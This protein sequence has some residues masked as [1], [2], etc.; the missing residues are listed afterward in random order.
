MKTKLLIV[1]FSICVVILSLQIK[2]QAFSF[3][4][5]N[6][7]SDEICAWIQ[8]DGYYYLPDLNGEDIEGVKIEE[9]NIASS[10]QYIDSEGTTN[11]ELRNFDASG[12]GDNYLGFSED[13][14]YVY[15]FTD[16]SEKIDTGT[17]CYMKT[18]Y[19]GTTSAERSRYI[20]KVDSNVFT[21]VRPVIQKDGSVIYKKREDEAYGGTLFCFDGKQSVSVA[22]NIVNFMANE[23]NVVY[24]TRW[25]EFSDDENNGRVGKYDLY[26]S[27]INKK[28]SERQIGED[29][30]DYNTQYNLQEIYYLNEDEIYFLEGNTLYKSS[31]DGMKE[32]LIE[33][34]LYTI[35]WKNTKITYL[36]KDNVNSE[37]AQNEDEASNVIYG[38][39][40]MY[41]CENGTDEL[42]S[43]KCKI[44]LNDLGD[45]EFDVLGFPFITETDGKMVF[46]YVDI[47]NLDDKNHIPFYMEVA[48][49]FEPIYLQ[50][51]YVEDIEE[52]EMEM[53]IVFLFNH[54]C[55]IAICYDS[56]DVI[57]KT[58]LDNNPN[59]IG[60]MESDVTNVS[61]IGDNLFWEKNGTVYWCD[62]SNCIPIGSAYDEYE[63]YYKGYID[64]TV[65]MLVYYTGRQY[66]GELVEI[67][68]GKY[69]YEIDSNVTDFWKLESG[70]IL[71]IKEGQLIL[72]SN[73]IKTRISDNVKKAWTLSEKTVTDYEHTGW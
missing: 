69:E 23:E 28:D 26:G 46:S 35:Q 43:E 66:G 24:Y 10:W 62:G 15:F 50:D 1:V 49:S 65:L 17:L 39:I 55:N 12:A 63:T 53:P 19:L 33:D 57:V 34:N 60:V 37:Y 54:G 47:T 59:E 64:R 52:L 30:Y 48:G 73:G 31:Y 22:E 18:E 20:I 29:I 27:I 72:Y 32:P 71:Y 70:G 38:S 4:E 36:K 25:K 7:K 2:C 11:D 21:S 3:F 51:I 58:L 42:L 8:D 40:H 45:G 16:I 67:V 44:K 13:K 56:G 68:D 41:D 14:K 5:K 61:T 9:S 6:K